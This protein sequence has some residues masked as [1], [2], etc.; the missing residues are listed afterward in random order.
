[1]AQGNS[2]AFVAALCAVLALGAT[3]LSAAPA[4][5]D[6]PTV[7]EGDVACVVQ[8]ANGNVRLCGGPTTTWDGQT[9]IDVNVILPPAPASGPDGPY[10]LIGDFHGWGGSKIGVQDQTQGWAEDG[11]AVFSMSDRGWGNSCGGADPEK[12]VPTKCG[13]GY[14]HLMDD[15][16]EVRDAQYLISVLADEGVAQPQKIGATGYSYGG[17]MSM[18]LAALRNRTMMP[19][20]SLV[21]WESPEGTPM[22]LAAAVPQWPWTDLAYSLMPNGRTLDYV[23]DSPYLGPDGKAPI[24]VEKASFVAALYGLGLALSNY[25]TP[26]ADPSADLTSWYALVSAGEPYDSNPLA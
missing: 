4:S 8:P 10:P 6:F 5:A 20:G 21:P 22:E 9:K 13:A 26:G 25:A 11:Y 7:F 24:G 19:D 14:N 2:R 17:G 1:M 16:F 23:A 18:A 12:L 3:L 15:R